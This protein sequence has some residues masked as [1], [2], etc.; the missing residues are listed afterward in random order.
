[1]TAEI[2]ANRERRYAEVLKEHEVALKLQQTIDDRL[3][4]A[5]DRQ[6]A[7][8]K[9]RLAAQSNEAEAAEYAALAGDISTLEHMLNVAKSA[10]K[11]AQDMCHAGFVSNRE[12]DEEFKAQQAALEYAALRVKC[13]DVEKVFVRAIRAVGLAGK[14]IGH[15]TLGTSWQR[16]DALHRALDLGVIPPEA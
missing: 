15:H 13:E 1:M 10:T 2:I 11:D 5:S 7:I 4:E 14:K 9:R 8:T 6:K 16:S 3:R 12:A